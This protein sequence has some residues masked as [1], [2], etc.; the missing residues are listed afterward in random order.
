MCCINQNIKNRLMNPLIL[1]SFFLSYIAN[2]ISKK[3]TN[4]CIDANKYCLLEYL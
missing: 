1:T 3:L 2:S 4:I